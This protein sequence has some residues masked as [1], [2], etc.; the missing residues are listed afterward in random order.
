VLSHGP[1]NP[2]VTEGDQMEI[3]SGKVALKDLLFIRALKMIFC[4][5]SAVPG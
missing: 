5:V 2:E 4:I 3:F 1:N